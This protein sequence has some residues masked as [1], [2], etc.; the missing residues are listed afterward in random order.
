MAD[1]KRCNCQGGLKLV[2]A[3]SGAADTAEMADRA[4]RGVHRSGEAR[5][6]C[7]AGIGGGVETILN[8]TRAAQKVVVLDGCDTDCA[9]KLMRKAGIETFGHLRVVD[10]ASS[11]T[12]TA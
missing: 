9:A 4:A 10:P 8:N 7:L 1:E 12:A 6:Y 2:F 11:R 5:M 3:C